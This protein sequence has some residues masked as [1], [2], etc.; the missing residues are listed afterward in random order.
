MTMTNFLVGHDLN[1][2]DKLFV[3]YNFQMHVNFAVLNL[4]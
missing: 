4:N 1:D 2:Y 3:G